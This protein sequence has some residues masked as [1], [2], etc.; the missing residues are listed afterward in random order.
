[1]GLGFSFFFNS[2]LLGIGLAMDAFSVS[3]ANGL[4]EPTMGKRKMTGVAGIFSAFQ[5][6]MPLIGWGCVSTITQ[7]FKI[8]EKLIPWIALVLLGYIGG[9]MLWE[10]IRCKDLCENKPAVG[11]SALLMQGFATS[12]DALSVGFT[13]AT[14]NAIKAALACWCGDLHHQFYMIVLSR[15]TKRSTA[16]PGVF[17]LIVKGKTKRTPIGVFLVSGNLHPF[18]FG[19]L[20]VQRS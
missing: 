17:F 8:F 11:L 14:Y 7:H 19:H 3:L 18:R 16:S 10:G 4:N 20:Y 15:I 13:I 12:I 9:K 1:M 6:A 2:I 5:F